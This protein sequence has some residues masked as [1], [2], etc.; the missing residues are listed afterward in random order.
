MLFYNNLFY[1]I[2]ISAILILLNFKIFKIINKKLLIEKNILYLIFYYHLAFSVLFL[3]NDILSFL[4]I[5]PGSD[6]TSFFL[7]VGEKIVIDNISFLPGD[8]FLFYL[9]FYLKKI[10][11]DYISIHFLFGIFGSLS[12]LIFY[13][14][15][16]KFFSGKYDKYLVLFFILLPSYNYW[17]SGI[18]KDVLSVF[19]LSI[20]IYSYLRNDFK[21]LLLA[22][23]LLCLTRLHLGFLCLISFISTYVFLNFYRYIFKKE[24]L[25]FNKKI[26]TKNILLVLLALLILLIFMINFYTIEYILIVDKVIFHFQNMYPGKNFIVATNFFGR[27]IEYCFRPYI[28][29]NNNFAAKIIS[30]ENT[31]LFFSLIFLILKISVSNLINKKI[32][33]LDFKIF[34]LFS[35]FLIAI[36]QI[37]LTSNYGIAIRQKWAFFPG[38]IF[39]LIYLKFILNNKILDK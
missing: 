37:L 27:L 29:E 36:F 17:T 39:I 9:I 25:F 6:S 24:I 12:I 22:F 3:L 2:C 5:T 14:C 35:F 4:N 16:A 10:S 33:R 34:I 20:F 1:S 19:C 8:N 7:N 13:G 38:I 15:A 31:F 30:L 23:L 21:L 18:S 11:L 28:W 26:N 32:I